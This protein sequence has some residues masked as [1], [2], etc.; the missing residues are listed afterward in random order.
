M[1]GALI[2]AGIGIALRPAG[3]DASASAPSFEVPDLRDPARTVSLDDFRGRPVVLNFFAAWCVPC[4]E[5]LPELVEAAARHRET[6]AFVGVDYQDSRSQALDLLEEFEV[7]YPAGYDP[8]G[9]VG[10]AYGVR[11]MPLTVFIDRHGTIVRRVDGRVDGDDLREGI[12]E[13]V[14]G[15]RDGAGERS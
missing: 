14:G 9:R 1:V 6:V 4:R 13:L 7:G 11:G 10:A 12:A 3:D 8:E 15:A 5:E 2:A